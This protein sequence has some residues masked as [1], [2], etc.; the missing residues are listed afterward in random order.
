MSS[1]PNSEN[2]N[3]NQKIDLSFLQTAQQSPAYVQTALRILAQREGKRASARREGI[4]RALVERDRFQ[5]HL[6]GNGNGADSGIRTTPTSAKRRS[7]P[8]ALPKSP[9]SKDPPSP[10]QSTSSPTSSDQ[11]QNQ[12][13]NPMNEPLTWYSTSVGSSPLHGTEN[14]YCDV[15]PYDRTRV[16]LAPT[17]VSSPPP[18]PTSTS[19]SH[20]TNEDIESGDYLNASWVHEFYGKKT[21]IAT[22]APL[23]DTVHTFLRVLLGEALPPPLSSTSQSGATATS[24][25]SPRTIVQLTRNIESGMRKAHQYLPE[26]I[27]EESAVVVYPPPSTFVGPSSPSSQSSRSSVDS[28]GSG[29]DSGRRR[30]STGSSQFRS[31]NLAGSGNAAQTE[32]SPFR[33]TLLGRE[34]VE[35]ARG[36]ICIVRLDVLDPSYVSPATKDDGDDN[37]DDYGYPTDEEKDNSRSASRK[38]TKKVSPKPAQDSQKVEKTPKVLRSVTF[39]HLLFHAWPD[40]GVPEDHDL[41]GLVKFVGL[42]D[43][44]NRLPTKRSDTDAEEDPDPPIMIN[45]SAGIGRTGSFIAISSLLRAIGVLLPPGAPLGDP[46]GAQSL[47]PSPERDT[48]IQAISAELHSEV[49]ESGPLGPIPPSHANDMVV[50]EID[51]LREQRPGMVQRPEQVVLVYRVFGGVALR[52]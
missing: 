31:A 19:R 42:V 17:S 6:G 46:P 20:V 34:E 45:C 40:H 11:N 32:I 24:H 35:E 27:G 47:S 30:S 26:K 9:K 28:S 36:I 23:P 22:Q 12:S 52:R 48:P 10:S 25:G 3:Q 39:R 38:D 13:P 29:S 1:T 21:W 8:W 50:R 16:V 5:G 4:L 14:R 33:L 7:G 2:Q 43:E 41:A 44:V 51:W 37:E 15:V 49:T 18:T